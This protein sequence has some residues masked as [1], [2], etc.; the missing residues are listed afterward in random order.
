MSRGDTAA[1]E[2]DP[3]SR[4]ATRPAL[5]AVRRAAAWLHLA[6]ASAIVIGVF[7]QVYLIGSYIFG[8]GQGALDAHE[9]AGFVV[10]GLEVIVFLAALVAWLPR[11]D[12]VLSPPASRARR[13]R[14]RI[15][16]RTARN[17]TTPRRTT[18]AGQL[19][20]TD[21]ALIGSGI[22]K[23]F[24]KRLVLDGA[25]L[26]LRPG[27]VVALVGENGAGKS[28]G[29]WIAS[30]SSSRRR[31]SWRRRDGRPLADSRRDAGAR[32]PSQAS[33]GA[34]ARRPADEL[35]RR[36]GRRRN[37][38]TDYDRSPIGPGG[39]ILHSVTWSVLIALAA[40]K[41]EVRRGPAAILEY[42]AVWQVCLTLRLMTAA[43]SPV[44]DRRDRT[45]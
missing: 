8:A 23:R 3:R 13:A 7:V 28:S 31:G 40:L 39:P 37:R 35:V 9:T 45:E 20:R 41:S 16:A 6:L 10:Q 14:P 29:A 2:L 1:I 17:P 43:K 42:A 19:M 22:V 15:S 34:P 4:T 21:A 18:P 12:L 26:V 25:A 5:G 30:S 33:G 27:E 32:P 36:G 44:R 38:L 24:G 11:L